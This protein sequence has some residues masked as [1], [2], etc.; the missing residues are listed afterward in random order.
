MAQGDHSIPVLAIKD[1]R[2]YFDTLEGTA[3]AVDGLSISLHHGETL[4]VVGESGC[5]KSVAALSILRLIPSPPG[6]IV[7]GQILFQGRNLLSMPMKRMRDIRGNH[8]SMIFQEPMTSLNPVFGIGNQLSKAFVLHQHLSKKEAR[9]RSIEMLQACEIAS[10]EE[11]MGS[12]PH[13]LSGGMRQRAMIAMALACN[14]KILIADEPTTALDVTVQAQILDLV[15]RLKKE[16]GMAMILITHNL[17]IIARGTQRVIVMYAGEKV[18]EGDTF[19]IFE[20]PRHPYTVAL[21]ESIP[22]LGK[23]GKYL[24]EIK[25]V[26]PPPYR[27][28]R[29]CKFADRCPEAMERCHKEKPLLKE[30]EEGH[31]VAC[32]R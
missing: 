11:M 32:F 18:E 3:K 26:V 6:R 17:G 21:M 31:W 30:T 5:G 27:V 25:G 12:Y 28:V 13:Q 4:G 9:R 23:K 16:F 15:L 1:L 24:K 19:S 29:G 22:V 10:P 2:I 8:I 14:P 7:S 20:K